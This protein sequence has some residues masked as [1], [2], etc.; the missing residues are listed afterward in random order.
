VRWKLYSGPNEVTIEAP[1]SAATTV[2]VSQP[3]LYLFELSAADG[4]HA[5]A[6]DAVAISVMP[7]V[8][9]AN[10]ST[11]AAIGVA[12]NVSIGGFIVQGANPK[13]VLIRAIGPS[14]SQF[15]V[16]GALVDPTLELHDASGN[17]LL[18]N[19]NWKDSQEQAISETGLAPRDGRESA[20]RITLDPGSYTAIVAGKGNTSGIG[21]T[22]I[23]EVQQSG[24]RL[25]NISTRGS[26]GTSDAVMIGGLIVTGTA[27]ATILFRAIGPSLAGAGIANPLLDPT[28]DLFDAQGAPI[29]SNDDW[30]GAQ[31]V[32]IASTNLAPPNE[33]EAALLIDL[34]PGSYTAVVRGANSTTGIAL[35][36]AY[37]LP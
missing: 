34:N 1:G 2:T 20:I 12:E 35:I 25:P 37:H 32:A 18:F 6:Y 8:R 10:I 13:D 17:L 31:E 27:P 26:V 9:M 21:L 5:V 28:I 36:E 29:A 33:S 4:M 24:S 3:G 11:R 15:G 7:P 22:E 30:K 14:L 16:S 19:D 23:Y